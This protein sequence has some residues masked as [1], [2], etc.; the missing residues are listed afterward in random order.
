MFVGMFGKNDHLELA[1]RFV[2]VE[3]KERKIAAI[4]PF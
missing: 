1:H 3:I 2:F 4:F